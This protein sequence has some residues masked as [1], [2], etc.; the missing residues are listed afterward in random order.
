MEGSF[1]CRRRLKVL[2]VFL[3]EQAARH[4]ASVPVICG[5]QPACV[6]GYKLQAPGAHGS[7]QLCV[8]SRISLC[9]V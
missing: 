2:A 7:L 9:P 6:N 1:H 4:A 3:S 8:V 5:K